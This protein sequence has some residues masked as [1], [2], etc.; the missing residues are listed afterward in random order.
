MAKHN[1]ITY[2]IWMNRLMLFLTVLDSFDDESVN[3]TFRNK[4]NGVTEMA[5]QQ[6]NL[7]INLGEIR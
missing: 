2:W 7:N 4:K 1:A 5:D 6:S 3:S